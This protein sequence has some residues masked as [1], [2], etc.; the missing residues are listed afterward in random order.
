MH[1]KALSEY[2]TKLERKKKK[3]IHFFFFTLNH[4]F[5]LQ[6]ISMKTNKCF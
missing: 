1:I 2:Q 5:C 3:E 6:K 4:F